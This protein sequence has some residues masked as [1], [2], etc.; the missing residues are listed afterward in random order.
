MHFKILYS[1]VICKKYSFFETLKKRIKN[2]IF[3]YYSFFE[4]LYFT[5]QNWIFHR[6]LEKKLFLKPCIKTKSPYN[7]VI[8]LTKKRPFSL[9][10]RVLFSKF[11]QWLHIFFL[12]NMHLETILIENVNIWC[13]LSVVSSE[14]MAK[15]KLK[16]FRQ[17]SPAIESYLNYIS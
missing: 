1:I 5:F 3:S 14:K 17:K 9:Q 10:L 11:M 8:W 2:Q 6:K 12:K 15:C 16:T 7:T 4:W 13:F